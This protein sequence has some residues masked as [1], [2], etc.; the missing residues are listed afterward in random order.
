MKILKMK[1]HHMVTHVYMYFNI[2]I[3][4]TITF[5]LNMENQI[6]EEIECYNTLMIKKIKVLTLKLNI[7]FI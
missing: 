7:L 3:I 6:L 2:K 4:Q 1:F 5:Y